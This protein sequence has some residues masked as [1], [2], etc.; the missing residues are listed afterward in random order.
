MSLFKCF[1]PKCSQRKNE[2]ERNGKK[3]KEAQR[4][5]FDFNIFSF[6]R[7]SVYSSLIFFYSSFFNIYLGYTVIF[8]FLLLLRL[9]IFISIIRY[10]NFVSVNEPYNNNNNNNWY[11]L[12]EIIYSFWKTGQQSSIL[13]PL[14]LHYQPILFLLLRY[15]CYRYI[16]FQPFVNWRSCML[17]YLLLLLLLLLLWALPTLFARYRTF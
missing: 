11:I 13:I 12:I 3:W 7:L 14:P 6:S 10:L 9:L 8:F 2:M 4:K 17:P 15:C 1:K 5:T 16:R